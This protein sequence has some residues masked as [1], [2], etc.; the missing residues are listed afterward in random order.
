MLMHPSFAPKVEK[1]N[2]VQLIELLAKFGHNGLAD[3]TDVN[4]EMIKFLPQEKPEEKHQ[5][6]YTTE[7]G[8]ESPFTNSADSI[9]KRFA[10][11]FKAAF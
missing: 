9:M 1:T 8:N 10:D 3:L 5:L 6:V 4:A 2:P 7:E 11:E